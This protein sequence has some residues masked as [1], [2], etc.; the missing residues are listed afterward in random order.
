MFAHGGYEPHS[1][2]MSRHTIPFRRVV[3]IIRG[4]FY[5]KTRPKPCL[6]ASARSSPCPDAGARPSPW[7]CAVMDVG[8]NQG[9][10]FHTVPT[11]ATATAVANDTTTSSATATI[12][13]SIT[14]T[15]IATAAAAATTAGGGALCNSIYSFTIT[16]ERGIRP[17]VDINKQHGHQFN[18]RDRL[19]GC[20]DRIVSIH[21]CREFQ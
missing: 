2:F 14:I 8:S 7:S 10:T 18:G 16:H 5:A 9:K 12:S 13:T 17:L 20:M 1:S 21:L 11:I 19:V 15:D 3:R 6:D 4:V